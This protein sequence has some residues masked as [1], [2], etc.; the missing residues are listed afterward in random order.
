ME[1]TSK[2]HRLREFHVKYAFHPNGG[3]IVLRIVQYRLTEVTTGY[4]ICVSVIFMDLVLIQSEASNT[5][6]KFLKL[7]TGSNASSYCYCVRSLLMLTQRTS[8]STSIEVE[9]SEG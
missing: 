3:V 1:T 6:S 9:V 5:C 4:S 7:L 2:I 8:F